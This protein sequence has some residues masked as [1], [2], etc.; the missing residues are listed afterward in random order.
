MHHEH[1]AY[2]EHLLQTRTSTDTPQLPGADA[3]AAEVIAAQ[4]VAKEAMSIAGAVDARNTKG[5]P[6]DKDGERAWSTGLCG[7][8]SVPGKCE[9]ALDLIATANARLKSAVQV[10]RGS[11]ARASFMA[12]L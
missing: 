4:P 1:Q 3:P 6:A 12:R 5:V 7:C 8:C 9:S 2:F 11:V 10:W